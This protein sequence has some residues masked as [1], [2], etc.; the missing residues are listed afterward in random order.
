MTKKEIALKIQR[1]GWAMLTSKEKDYYMTAVDDSDKTE[2]KTEKKGISEIIYEEAIRNLGRD[3]SP[4]ENEFGC[5][6]SINT[7]FF[8]ATGQPLC[9]SNSTTIGYQTM[10]SSR[11][12]KEVKEPIRGDVIIS[13]T[14]YSTFRPTKKN[15]ITNGHIGIVMDD[16]VIASNDSKT[17]LFKKNYTLATWKARWEIKGKYPTHY[18]RVL[19]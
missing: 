19:S 11:R 18:F 14:G 9:N 15:P 13:P 3:I 10:K 7:L 4:R 16:G 17:S 5:Q 6:E 12:F 2:D 1:G 8:F